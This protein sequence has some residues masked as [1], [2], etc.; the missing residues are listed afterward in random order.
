MTRTA[1]VAVAAA[2]VVNA[3]RPPSADSRMPAVSTFADNLA[4]LRQ[5]TNVVVLADG[6]GA[7]V[8]VA[9]D[10]QGRVMTSTA[11]A[12][13]AAFESSSD[14]TNTGPA[15]WTPDAGL[16]SIW[17]LGQFTPTPSTTIAIPFVPGPETTRGP[18]VNDAY[19]GKVPADRLQITGNV[20]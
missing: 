18:I 13:T 7:Q 5:H 8:V 3:P 11:G 6:S 15:A 20:I 2:F 16:M 19:F 10:Y 1:I 12:R 4:F 17:I 14:V 9:P